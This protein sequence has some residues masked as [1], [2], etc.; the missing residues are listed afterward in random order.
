MKCFFLQGI[1]IRLRYFECLPFSCIIN[2]CYYHID[3]QI[4]YSCSVKL[5]QLEYGARPALRGLQ[6]TK[7]KQ[8]KLPCEYK[9]QITHSLVKIEYNSEVK[10][11]FVCC[12]RP[13]AYKN[14]NH[15]SLRF[16]PI[17]HL[18]CIGLKFSTFTVATLLTS[19]S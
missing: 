12:Y 9:L 15:F 2:I 5:P 1:C 18:K 14:G 8:K 10:K 7:S 16:M 4:F 13:F 11:F 19:E 3:S 17:S 6:P